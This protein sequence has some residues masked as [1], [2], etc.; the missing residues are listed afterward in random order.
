MADERLTH[1]LES[2]LEVL[3]R[4][5]M[6]IVACVAVV[7]ASAFGFSRS[8]TKEYTAA[9]RLLFRD[10][11]L[12]AQA[13]GLPRVVVPDPQRDLSTNLK[14]LTLGDVGDRTARQLDNGITASQVLGSV[15]VT[16][17]GQT[18]IATVSAT[19]PSARDAATIANAF[20]EQFIESRR[21]SN[22]VRVDAARRLV[23]RQLAGLSP[24]QQAGVQGQSLRERGES[25]RI[26]ASLQTGNVELAQ[27]AGVP[28]SPSAPRVKRDTFLGAV[29]GLLFGLGLA[30]VIERLDR[31][32]K[33]PA[34]LESIFGLPVL[35]LVP[36]SDAYTPAK[37]AG[38][39]LALPLREDEAFRMLRAHLRYF[40]V[41]RDVRTVLV[42]SAS[43]GE[44]KSTVSCYLA[45]AAA[46]M[47][48][49]T[50]LIDADF[51]RPTLHTRL[52]FD[53][54]PNFDAGLGEVL[55][56]AS[57][58]SEAIRSVPVG[59]QT[60][61][62]SSNAH[63]DALLVGG[64]PPNPAEL[65]ESGAM[66]ELLGWAAEQYELVVVDTPPLTVVSDAIPLLSQVDGVVIVSRFGVSTR[67]DAERI[68]D[69]LAS[70][71][72]PLL[73]VVGN[74]YANRQA[75]GY[76]YYYRR[77]REKVT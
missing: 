11:G 68:R 73:G 43:S 20:V 7:A 49:K 1:N 32:L 22:Q 59:S 41:D 6:L 75:I 23:E 14:L 19:R 35:G 33:E 50:L 3:R 16:A 55:I 58:A 69:R 40:N 45:Q 26:L 44:G 9:A 31:R 5:A 60:V 72:A 65:L 62:G 54:Q 8:Q 48:T 42:T 27:R 10:P 30:F 24:Q 71:G 25:L 37:S 47:G 18:D 29:M 17:E 12:D 46:K 36:A 34:D 51:R 77:S 21:R 76:D 66:R 56:G 64:L 28:T 61:G 13:S 15:E 53:R 67:D 74:A 52:G 2:T 39:R 70:L 57:T 63:L 38:S 4:R